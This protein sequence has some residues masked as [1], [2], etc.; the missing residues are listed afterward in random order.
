MIVDEV[1]E[2]LSVDA[3]EID[4]APPLGAKVQADFIQGMAKVD[5]RLVILLDIDKVLTHEELAT[6][7]EAILSVP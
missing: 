5:H 1:S 3:A 4:A 6:V 7:E 2:V